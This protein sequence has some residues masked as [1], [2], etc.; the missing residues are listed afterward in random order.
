MTKRDLVEDTYGHTKNFDD[1]L[2]SLA[3]STDKKSKKD[4]TK[5]DKKDKMKVKDDNGN[6]KEKKSKKEKNKKK[7]KETEMKKVSRPHKSRSVQ[8]KN[9]STY[10]AAQLKEIFGV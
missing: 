5:K 3:T 8:S 10:S 4:K 9:V 2:K 7:E 6:R 1:L